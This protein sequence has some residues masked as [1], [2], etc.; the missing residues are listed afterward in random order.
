MRAGWK[1]ALRATLSLLA[2]VLLVLVSYFGIFKGK[3]KVWP[4]SFVFGF[5]IFLLLVGWIIK[6]M[7]P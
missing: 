4:A 7:S 6:V 2:T 1:K 3:W 5:A